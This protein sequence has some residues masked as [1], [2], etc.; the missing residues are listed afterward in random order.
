MNKT[1]LGLSHRAGETAPS[2]WTAHEHPNA[3]GIAVITYRLQKIQEL[4]NLNLDDDDQRLYF[5]VSSF[6]LEECGGSERT[7]GASWRRPILVILILFCLDF[8]QGLPQSGFLLLFGNIRCQ[9]HRPVQVHHQ[10]H[11][12]R[13]QDKAHKYQ[14]IGQ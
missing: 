3:H 1:V 11:Q 10:N 14:R 4:F 5:L 12:Q 7:A 6:L 2:L 13:Q 9:T 8:L